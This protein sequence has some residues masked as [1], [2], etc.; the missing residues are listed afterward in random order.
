MAADLVRAR[1]YEVVDLGCDIPAT[2]FAAATARADGVVV[3]AV[4][5]T[6]PGGEAA[7]AETIAHVKE[8][9]PDVPIFAGGAMVPDAGTAAALGADR[10]AADIDGLAFTVASLAG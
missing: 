6:T 9:R 5:A 8:T 7:A 10:W 4:S 3:V 2:A 1:G